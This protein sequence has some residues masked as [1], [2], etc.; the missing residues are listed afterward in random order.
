MSSYTKTFIFGIP[1]CSIV[2]GSFLEKY[3]LNKKT[4]S[5]FILDFSIFM[6][7][8]ICLIYYF[9]FLFF[10]RSKLPL[11]QNKIAATALG[12]GSRDMALV[13]IERPSITLHH[14]MQ[15]WAPQ[16]IILPFTSWTFQ[17]DIIKTCGL[18][19]LKIHSS[20]WSFMFHDFRRN[21]PNI[22]RFIL[23]AAECFKKSIYQQLVFFK[24]FIKLTYN[25]PDVWQL[26]LLKVPKWCLMLPLVV[27]LLLP[28]CPVC[29]D[30][31]P[32]VRCFQCSEFP[33][34]P[35]DRDEAMGPCPGEDTGKHGNKARHYYLV[36]REA[37][38]PDDVRLES[39]IY[40]IYT[41]LQRS[42]HRTLI[43]N[44]I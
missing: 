17:K 20:I 37:C 9:I 34:Q 31:A 36:K 30:L 19:K 43:M 14:Q 42:S 15:K 6:L 40:T 16:W 29:P 2:F 11:V 12:S 22:L 24:I 4:R 13:C 41:Y 7:Y 23:Q 3:T 35:G 18:F 39:V 44:I 33:A 1:Y 27:T 38:Y 26:Y 5:T 8:C 21:T 25:F 10:I 32:A 28:L